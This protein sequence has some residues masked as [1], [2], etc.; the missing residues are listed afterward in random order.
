MNELSLQEILDFFK[1]FSDSISA[2]LQFA[3]DDISEEDSS[4]VGVSWHL[5]NFTCDIVGLVLMF[6]SC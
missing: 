2:D 5:G 4:A 6:G 3:I 1:Q